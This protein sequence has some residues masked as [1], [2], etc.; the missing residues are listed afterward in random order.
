MAIKVSEIYKSIQGESSYAGLPCIFIRL[1]GCNL[2]CS[3]CDTKY[4][5]YEGKDYKI[6]EIIGILEKYKIRLVEI[7]GGEPLMQDDTKIL[8]DSLVQNDYKVLIETNGSI[9]IQDIN[10]A[11]VIIMDIK[12]PSSGMSDKVDFSNIAYLK[13][14]DEVKFVI[15]NRQ[16]YEWS[17]GIIK[18]HALLEKCNVLFSPVFNVMK[19]E[20]LVQWI[21]EDSLNVR[22]NLQLHKYISV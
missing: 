3:Y 18:K 14:T 22:L 1:T 7:T 9:S 21:L 4:A 13:G 15:A 6:D 16:D 2:R 11:A 17:A 20:K 10:S 5:Y 12:T 19:P 8:V